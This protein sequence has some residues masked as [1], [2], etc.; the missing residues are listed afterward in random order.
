[1]NPF[2][3]FQVVKLFEEPNYLFFEHGIVWSGDPMNGTKVLYR[4]NG[5]CREI[6]TH[7]EG[8]MEGFR[9]T[10]LAFGSPQTLRHYRKGK[11]FGEAQ[12]FDRAGKSIEHVIYTGH[13]DEYEHYR[14][15]LA[16]GYP[17]H[18]FC[19]EDWD[20]AFVFKDMGPRG[21]SE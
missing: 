2:A 11:L 13:N 7:K 8:M 5:F 19:Q 15:D 1:M 21:W 14:D 3:R 4:R 18:R 20:V 6:V 17:N 12:L 16:K 10:Y 9:G